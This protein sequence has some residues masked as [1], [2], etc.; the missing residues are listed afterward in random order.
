MTSDLLPMFVMMIVTMVATVPLAA[1]RPQSPADGWTLTRTVWG[2]PDLQGNWTNQSRT[3]TERRHGFGPTLTQAQ[4]DSVQR[5]LEA[6]IEDGVARSDPDR[7][8]PEAGGGVG[9]YNEIYYDRGAGIAI[10]NGEARSSLIT[11]PADGRI[12]AL[13]ARGERRLQAYHDLRLRFGRA[14]HPEVL[15]QADRCLVSYGSTLGP[16]ML[17]SGGYNSN[18]TIV[19]GRDHVVI[20]TEMVHDLRII[21]LEQPGERSGAELP[22]DI[23]PWFGISRGWWEGNTLVVET[24]NLNPRQMFSPTFDP[25]FTSSVL[26]SDDVR[27]EE[28]FTRADEHTLLYEFEVDDP[29]TYV[30]KWGGQVPMMRFDDLLYEYACHEGNYAME[31]ILSGARYQER[32]GTEGP[33]A[34]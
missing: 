26:F 21:P 24:T 2:H 14:D 6:R 25:E 4:A 11:L 29:G 22:S 9:G 30:E 8:P 7:P 1:Q 10:V 3:P 33:R 23:R 28:R 31:G 5:A 27:I 17:P 12:P 18:Y 32:A 20:L 34:R 13:S 16:P 19:Q 15:T